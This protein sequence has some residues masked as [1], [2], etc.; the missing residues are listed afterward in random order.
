MSVID[1]FDG[2]HRFL[3]NFSG[4]ATSLDGV[5]Y[6][7]VEHAYQAAK[8]LNL[9]WR[10][11]IRIQGTPG[12]A[13]R[14]GRLVPL[15]GGWDQI[16]VDVMQN[17][18]WEKFAEDSVVASLLLKTHPSILIEGNT[19]HDRFWGVCSC[20]RCEG[21]GQN[22]LGRLLMKQRDMLKART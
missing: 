17:L 4:Y 22:H 14:M 9:A 7:T 15:R 10:E 12:A 16:K 2:E 19:W 21:V 6:K 13:K 20:A 18:L 11:E 8:T 1:F 3:S 5:S